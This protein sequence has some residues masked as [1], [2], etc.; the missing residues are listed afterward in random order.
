MEPLTARQ[1]AILRRVVEA[2]IESAQPVGSHF[3][4]ERFQPRFSPA[5]I[6]HDMGWLEEIGYLTHPHTSAGRVPTDFGYRYYVDCCLNQEAFPENDVLPSID[7]WFE[8]GEEIESF[9]EKISE[10]LSTLSEEVS[11]VLVPDPPVE[12]LHRAKRQRLFLQGASTLLEK[13]E[14]QD[15]QKIRT[16]FRIFEDK[17]K[18]MNWLSSH[19]PGEGVLI[20]IGQENEPEVLHE[21]SVISTSYGLGN[22]HLGTIAVIGPRRMKYSRTIPLVRDMAQRI[23]HALR[24][25]RISHNVL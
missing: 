16:L 17:R 20:T 11:L 2:H 22:K 1:H 23:A 14:F 19:G 4:A 13:P 3:I 7:R 12:D 18:L 9:A 25:E 6:R 5:T 10:V 15:V 8:E 24:E 21:C